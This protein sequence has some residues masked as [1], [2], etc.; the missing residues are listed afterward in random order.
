MPKPQR[1][2][3]FDAF[4][5]LIIAVGS[6]IALGGCATSGKNAIAGRVRSAARSAGGIYANCDNAFVL[7]LNDREVLRNSN[8][9]VTPPPV[10]VSLKPGD[11][12]K[13]RVSDFGGGYGF[14]FLYC[15]NDKSKYFSA[16]TNN[17]YTY[18]PADEVAWWE[19]PDIDALKLAPASEGSAKVVAAELQSLTDAPCK[20][21]I[22][23]SAGEPTAFLIHVVSRSD[24]K[25]RNRDWVF[26]QRLQ[27]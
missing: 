18:S 13:V 9:E 15:S 1:R 24:L 26:N 2:G 12:I 4:A 6:S 22:W 17:W 19:V 8:W 21:V 3:M 20:S 7:Y 27:P 14:A 23:G 10:P 25:A 5:M 11:V 16:N